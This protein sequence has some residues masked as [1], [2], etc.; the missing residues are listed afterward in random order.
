MKNKILIG[1]AIAAFA[2]AAVIS[3]GALGD[4]N[5]A[6]AASGSTTAS[7]V[8]PAYPQRCIRVQY[9]DVTS[10]KAGSVLKAYSGG[11]VFLITSNITSGTNFTLATTT[12]TGIGSNSIIVVQKATNNYAA[13]VATVWGT[14]ATQVFTTAAISDSFSTNDEIFLMSAPIGAQIGAATVRLNNQSLY[15]AD[16]GKPIA[17]TLDG[18][19]ACGISNAVGHYDY[20]GQ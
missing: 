1:L 5:Y 4:G 13:Y 12:G 15:S 17:L 7:V 10:D 14:N 16:A 9:A 8:F 20:P 19:S 2:A 6:L 18:T 11:S 3:R